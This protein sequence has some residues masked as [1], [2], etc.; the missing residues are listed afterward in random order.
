[1]TGVLTRRGNL[2]TN[3][4]IGRIPCK[5][6]NRAIYKPKTEALGE[7]PTVSDF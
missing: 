1:M 4:H 2:E 3:S 6:M 7:K 5:L